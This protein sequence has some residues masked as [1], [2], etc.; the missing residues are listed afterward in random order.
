MTTI[1]AILITALIAV[2]SG[3]EESAIGDHG[4][5]FGCLQITQPVLDDIKRLTGQEFELR[6]CLDRPTS[7]KICLVYLSHYATEERIGRTPTMRDMARIWNGGPNG[8]TKPSTLN[9]WY[10]VEREID[11]LNLVDPMPTSAQLAEYDRKDSRG[12]NGL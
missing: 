1:P 6:D 9:Y 12:L 5:A 3:G 8:W 11:R 10:K 7:V 2:E 4:H